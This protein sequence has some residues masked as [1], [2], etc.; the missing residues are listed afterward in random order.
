MKRR[1]S[2]YALLVAILACFTFGVVAC[3]KDDGDG[4][5][6]PRIVLE[7][8]EFELAL[9]MFDT[10]DWQAPYAGVYYEN[11]DRVDGVEVTASLKDPTGG[12]VYENELDYVNKI[13]I[14]MFTG[15]YELVYSAEGCADAVI[16]IYVCERLEMGVDFTLEN[17][18]L[19]WDE[20]YGAV[21][22]DVTV[23]GEAPVFTETASFTSDIFAGEGFYVGVTAKGDNKEWIDSYMSSYENRISLKDGELAAFNNPCYELDV[24]PA[25]PNNLNAPPEQIE[26]LTEEECAGSTGGA[27]KMLLKSGEYGPALFRVYLDKT[28]DK[29]EDFDGMEIR[30][31]LDSNSYTYEEL[32]DTTRF[33]LAQPSA[34]ERRVGRGTY[35][36]EGHNDSWQVVKIAKGDVDNFD[37]LNYLQFSLYNMTRSGGKGYLYLDYI[38]LYKD[39][40]ET[41]TNVAIGEDKLDWDDVENAASYI[42]SVDKTDD[43]NDYLHRSLYTVTSSEIALADLG[44]DP[45]M[46]EQQYEVQVMAVSAD[47]A[48]GSSAWS[49][50]LVKRAALAEGDVAPFDNAIYEMDVTNTANNSHLYWKS[51]DMATGAE[52]GK[53]ILTVFNAN[54][55]YGT[56]SLFTVN[57]TQPLDLENEYD[58]LILRFQLTETNYTS[59]DTLTIQLLNKSGAAT[60]LTQSITVGEWME[61]QIAMDDLK[62][63]YAT[64]DTQLSFQITNELANKGGGT[65]YLKVAFDYLRYY[66]TLAAPQNVRV[67]GTSLKWD[68]VDGASGYTVNVNGVAYGGIT[69]TS[70]DISAL[71]GANTFKVLANSASS[72]VASSVYS[73]EAYYEIL[74]EDCIASFNHGGYGAQVEVSNPNLT[75]STLN[76]GAVLETKYDAGIGNGG[77]LIVRLRAEKTVSGGKGHIFTVSLAEGLDLTNRKAVQITFCVSAW[78]RSTDGTSATSAKFMVLHATTQDLGYT[79]GEAAVSAEVTMD[80]MYMNF[81]TLRLT[82]EQLKALGYTDGMT[83][84]TFSVWTNKDTFPNQGGSLYV[85]MDDISYCQMLATPVNARFEGNAFKWEAVDGASCYEVSVDGVV[86][87]V[88]ETTFDL[89]AYAETG[90]VKVMVRAIPENAEEWR[91][92][93]YT[94]SLIRFFLAENELANFNHALYTEA[95]KYAEGYRYFTGSGSGTWKIAP[96]YADGIVS[97]NLNKDYYGTGTGGNSYLAAFTVTLSDGIDLTKPG[98]KARIYM[99]YSSDPNDPMSVRLLHESDKNNW[100]YSTALAATTE[101]AGWTEFILSSAE[102]AKLGYKTGDKVLTFGVYTTTGSTIFGYNVKVMMDYIE[103]ASA[104]DEFL[105]APSLEEQLEENELA[106]FNQAG[107]TDVFGFIAGDT[108]TESFMDAPVFEKAGTSAGTVTLSIRND[109]YRGGT[110]HY[111]NMAAFT[112]TLPRGLDLAGDSVGIKIRLYVVESKQTGVLRLELLNLSEPTKWNDNLSTVFTSIGTTGEATTGWMELVV[113]NEQLTALGYKTGDTVLTLGLRNEAQEST[114]YKAQFWTVSLDYVE[115]ASEEDLPKEDES[116]IVSFNTPTAST[117]VEVGNPNANA[118]GTMTGTFDLSEVDATKGDGGALHLKVRGDVSGWNIAGGRSHIV[119]INLPRGLDLTNNAG[120]TITFCVSGWSGAAT[121]AT[122]LVLHATT[123]DKDYRNGEAKGG[124]TA[125]AVTMDA[126][127]EN[128]QTFTITA[129]QLKALGYEEGTNYI[130]VCVR[131][132]GDTAPGTGGRLHLWLDDISYYKEEE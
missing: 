14:P 99:E 55:T 40:I 16:T 23:N 87:T 47:T 105:K 17:G 27:L 60:N 95:V 73:A 76:G 33:I 7:T 102:I 21:G 124:T 129:E 15:K 132:T 59:L 112:I 91:P 38:R 130:T 43:A 48:T 6:N 3:N 81:Q 51:F 72:E 45:T 29:N 32:N 123:I 109:D 5:V 82:V 78:S 68:A 118:P 54:S 1:F 101:G 56:K 66:N 67:E 64:G 25:I 9:D 98:I 115:F 53:A 119:T 80:S 70:Y 89:S 69:E 18:T 107:Y 116:S 92:S 125:M 88:T 121:E 12:Y 131:T 97:F 49:T 19:T 2:L 20:V 58:C 50:K 110:S 10:M 8:D 35:V 28:I 104:T 79:A 11:L 30:F 36:Y 75:E 83:Y 93:E 128:F 127:V 4:R 41:P 42:V 63:F 90:A 24:E 13:M 71:T 126:N 39:T 22:Y 108:Y 122:F 103:Y 57:L 31:K 113:T 85:A 117:M 106:S 120:I 111:S 86:T 26:Y 100:R 34:D 96:M 62:E 74:A 52:G 61:Y 37:T 84:L 46:A 94:A 77:A 44:I 65:V 114:K